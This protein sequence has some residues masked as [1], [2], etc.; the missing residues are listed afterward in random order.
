MVPAPACHAT[1]PQQRA[2]ASAGA[3]RLQRLIAM[4]AV[5]AVAACAQEGEPESK[6]TAPPYF[7][8]ITESTGID[9]SY[10]SGDRGERW[11]PTI[12]GGGVAVFDAD[13]DGRPDIYLVDGND[14]L[15]GKRP[16]GPGGNRLYLQL[17]D[18]S[19]RD[20]TKESGL[21]DRHYGMGV[22][23]GDIDNDGRLDVY[24]TNYGPDRLF[25]NLGDGR[26]VDVT[27]TSGIAVDG[28][29]ASAV[30]CDFDGDGLL[31][32]YV[33]QYLH[34]HPDSRCFDPAGRRDYCGP[35]VFTPASDVLL[36]NEGGGRFQDVSEAMGITAVAGYGLGVVCEDFSGDG[37]M[38]FL[39]ANDGSAN[40][41]WLNQG[42]RFVEAGTAMGI[43]YNQ[44]GLPEAG[45]GIVA[46]DFL[47][48]GRLDVLMTHLHQ[49]TNT[50]YRNLGEG[51]FIDATGVVGLGVSS[52]PYTGFG[53][54]AFDID[55][56]GLQDLVVANGRVRS[57]SPPNPQAIVSP[58]W[59]R[60]AEPNQVFLHGPRG[61]FEV[62]AF[63]ECGDFCLQGEISRGL[64]ATDLDGNG[65]LDLVVVNI[66]SPTR[67]YRN[68][69]PR[70]GHWLR[71]RAWDPDLGRDAIGA[72]VWTR[73]D[74]GDQMRT[75]SSGGSYLSALEPRAH[76][77][78]GEA[79]PLAVDVSWPGGGSERFR[80]QCIDCEITLRRG[81]GEAMP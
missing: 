49:Q 62:Q 16:A 24:V 7:S 4:L 71:V 27:E 22:A 45:M 81:E 63:S 42:D 50:Y 40:H 20:A 54:F 65:A 14:D 28:F 38:D 29:S 46:A 66:E 53:V 51:Q 73:S 19:Y 70:R 77:G 78:L 6:A 47:G 13:G 18:G 17:E 9:F 12:M 56:D 79:R 1:H 58:P 3:G 35:Q 44:H 34:F 52:L 43:A 37:R 5:T 2:R 39:V 10:E 33:T 23:L 72:R 11:L 76:F 21:G 31:D 59:N 75:I 57:H 25:R 41:L 15:L 68:D 48:E 32:L 61:R 55:L 8:D 80:P 69:A 67:I 36:R 74:S 60:L 26:F 64:A 30:F